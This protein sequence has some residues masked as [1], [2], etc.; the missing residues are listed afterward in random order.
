MRRSSADANKILRSI[1]LL[2]TL[3]CL[4]NILFLNA[5]A[6]VYSSPRLQPNATITTPNVTLS[7]GTTGTEVIYTN[8]TSAK[9]TVSAPTIQGWLPNFQYRKKITFNNSAITQNLINFT[10]PIVFNSSNSDFWNHV[11]INGNDTRFIASDNTTELYFEFE[12]FNHTSDDMIAWV[13]VPQLDAISTT[14]YIWIYYG[15]STVDFDSYYKSGSV[16]DSDY[17]AVWHLGESP[18]DPSPQFKDST[19]NG[20]SGIAGNMTAGD[21]QAGKIDGS[22]H[23]NGVNSSVNAGNRPSLNITS[24]I[25]IEAWVKYTSSGGSDAKGIVAK[26]AAAIGRGYGLYLRYLQNQYIETDMRIG[27]TWVNVWYTGSTN[28][29]QW[30]YVVSTYNGSRLSLYVDGNLVNSTAAT[31]SIMSNPDSLV[32]GAFNKSSS[33]IY[34]NGTTD[35]V[36]I[37]KIARSANWNKACYQYEVDQSKFTYGTE[38][39]LAFDPVLNVVNQAAN[40]WSINMKAT[41]NSNIVR[42]SSAVISLYNATISSDQVII[43]SGSVTQSA[44]A[45]LNLPAGAGS[46]VYVSMSNLLA[47][48]TGSSYVNVYFKILMPNT[49]T[50]SLYAITFEID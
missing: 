41:S 9:V 17:E 34:Y 12:K 23:F 27:A 10:V 6:S 16:W 8:N 43:S 28:D 15:N 35:E 1:A 31:G 44:G 30:H 42:L 14:N 47:N 4:S 22:I 11:Q 48:T 49:T 39:A 5:S 3:F 21:Q 13:K 32:I 46:T 38:E 24:T 33:N 18:T 26:D 45:I 29:N 2:A 25:T 19:N 20:N 7:S 36:R 40:A 50:Y 37:S